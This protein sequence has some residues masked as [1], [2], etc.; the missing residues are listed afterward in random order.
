MNNIIN[1]NQITQK[2]LIPGFKGSFV[3]SSTMTVSYWQISKGSVLPEHSHH[4]EQISQVIKGE[5]ELTI[6]GKK[7]IMTPGLL[8]VIPSNAVHSG[9]ALTDCKIMD[10]FSPVREDYKF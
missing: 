8:A 10:I 4:H 2:E 5:F 6:D 3:H 7:H 9:V 1:L